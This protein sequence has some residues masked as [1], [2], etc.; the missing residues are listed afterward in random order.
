MEKQIELIPFMQKVVLRTT[1]TY[2]EDLKDDILRLRNAAQDPFAENRIFYWMARPCGT[3]LVTERNAFLRDSN[4][5]KIWTH[6]ADDFNG[7]Q[8]YRFV[9]TNGSGDNPMGTVRK[10]NYPEQVKRVE[11]GALPV[12]RVEITFQSGQ[13]REVLPEKLM[14]EREWLFNEYGIIKHIRYCPENEDELACVLMEEHRSQRTR[15]AK[16]VIQ[17]TPQ[18]GSR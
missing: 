14:E 10:L 8:A 9:V 2:R 3:W 15:R 4:G 16:T 12:V 11:K 7:I 13:V 18:R 5:F 1:K 17:K 6:Y